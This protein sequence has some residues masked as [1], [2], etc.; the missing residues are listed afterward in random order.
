MTLLNATMV[1]LATGILL[2][3]ALAL[4]IHDRNRWKTTATLRQKRCSEPS[5]SFGRK[6]AFLP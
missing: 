2:A 1:K 5:T 3:L 6:R 4:L